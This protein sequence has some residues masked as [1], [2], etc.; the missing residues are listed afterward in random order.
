MRTSPALLPGAQ[1][2]P[3]LPAGVSREGC[4]PC[5][6]KAWASLKA[7]L[8][9]QGAAGTCVV[10]GLTLSLHAG[11]GDLLLA[12]LGLTAGSLP[13]ASA[14]TLGLD[15]RAMRSRYR[16]ETPSTP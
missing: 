15:F 16:S 4:L 3:G 14:E 2:G 8:W 13:W 10:E 11:V 9:T 12:L 1:A 6:H 5:L 7:S